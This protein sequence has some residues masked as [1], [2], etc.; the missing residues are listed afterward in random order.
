MLSER[1]G[2]YK[3]VDEVNRRIAPKIYLDNT[4]TETAIDDNY[5]TVGVW[6]FRLNTPKKPTSR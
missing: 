2:N 3:V 4:L 5:P 6:G 1:I